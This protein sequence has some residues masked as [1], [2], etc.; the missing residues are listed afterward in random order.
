MTKVSIQPAAASG[1]W[2]IERRWLLIR[3]GDEPQPVA[4]L[5]LKAFKALALLGPAGAG[6]TTE[7]KRLAQVERADDRVVW[8]CRLADHS[9]SADELR[10][11]LDLLTDGANATTSIYLDALDEAMVPLRRAWREILSWIDERAIPVGAAVRITCRSAVWPAGLASRFIDGSAATNFGTALLQPL[12]AADVIAAAQSAGLDGATFMEHVRRFRADALASNALTL[13]LLLRL[14]QRGDLPTSIGDLFDRGM[15][16]LAEDRHER[17]ELGTDLRLSP[18]VILGAAERLACA[19]VL[20]GRETIDLSNDPPSTHLSSHDLEL[21]NESGS[22][23]LD[24]ETLADIGASGLCDSEFPATFRF[25]H[26]QIAEYLAG[27]RLARMLPHQ[28]RGLL[29]SPAGAAEGVAGPL[30]ETAAFAAMLN[31]G[32][33]EWIASTDPEIVGLSD[34]AD[35]QLR[36]TA[37]LGLLERCRRGEL[38]DAQVGRGEIVLDGLQYD[39]AEADLKPVLRERGSG[40]EDVLECAIELIKTWKLSSMSDDLADLM[41]DHT[42]PMEARKSAGHALVKIGTDEVKART[43][44]L[45]ASSPDDEIADLKGL[46]LR[47]NWPRGLTTPDLLAALTE[48]PRSNYHGAYDG[49]LW[50]L[51]RSC[52]NAEGFTVEGLR[53]ARSHLCR[54][55]DTDPLHRIAVRIVHHAVDQLDEP[56]VIVGLVD[57]MAGCAAAHVDSPL[58]ALRRAGFA[59]AHDEPE[60]PPA[61]DANPDARRRLI[62]ALA[63]SSIS[64]GDLWWTALRTPRLCTLDDFPWLIEQACDADRPMKERENYLHIARCLPWTTDLGCVEAW[65]AARGIDPVSRVLDFPLSV[66]LAS[67]EAKKMRGQWALMQDRDSPR[68]PVLLDPPPQERV[69]RCI[70]LAEAKDPKFF[71]NLCRAMT[72]EPASTHYG[73]ERDLTR[74]PGWQ[75]ADP[76]IRGRIV[77][78]A[79]RL[80]ETEAETPVDCR[81]W[82]SNSGNST[83]MS[84]ML[85]VAGSD[86]EW[87]RSR[88]GEWWLRWCHYVV[89]E[90]RLHTAE[91]GD[92]SVFDLLYQSVPAEVRSE[93]NRAST[94]PSAGSA[95]D[96]NRLLDLAMPIEDAVL[97]AEL[98]RR[99]ER[100]EVRED[101]IA[102]IAGFLLTRAPKL[103]V[104]ALLRCLDTPGPDTDDAA[105]VQ[106][107]TAMLTVRPPDHWDAVLAFVARNP[108]HGRR[109]LALFAHGAAYRR[110]NEDSPGPLA[111]FGP[112]RWAELFA[113]LLE[114][115]PPES[116]PVYEGAYFAG[117]DDSAR[118]LRGQLISALGDREDQAAV[119]A[120]RDLERRFGARYPWLRR[121]RAR[122]ERAWRL[123]QWLAL[124]LDVIGEVV[125]STERRLVRSEDDVLEGV[126]RAIEGY[127]R[128]LRQ[129]GAD[130]VEDLWNTASRRPP[131]PKAEEHVSGKICGAIR[132][133]FEDLAIAADREVEIHRRAVPRAAGG[134]P[135]SELDVLVQVPARGTMRGSQIRTPIEVKLSHNPEAK[136]AMKEQLADRYMPELGAMHGVYVVAWMGAPAGN[137]LARA[138]RPR[139]ASIEEARADLERQAAELAESQ[140]ATIVPI[141]IDASIR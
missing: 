130:T 112:A 97:D 141:V 25:A 83:C 77:A 71:I 114:H 126:R 15:R 79:K 85:L 42:A 80:L 24:R 51:E 10:R 102:P 100:G 94:D 127:E 69:L 93:V 140:G 23:P 39:D 18:D 115:F 103:S 56:G 122:A 26:R 84:A 49:F 47:C 36:R 78:A 117:S 21:L 60:L 66:D 86:P 109:V 17:F 82:P 44:P 119:D 118:N 133:Y 3:S 138:H 107:A 38:T 124:P 46:A 8:E 134:E 105:S 81:K 20:T 75:S 34:V 120:L 58:S 11:K 67:E 106:V 110:R 6:K 50:E 129:E 137:G 59:R 108:A 43:K 63:S 40:C 135:G 9:G 125:R 14:S 74:T 98:V 72:L 12:N 116:D 5:N 113:L 7:A 54:M 48:P 13:G 99:L 73:L 121:P 31:A 128:R 90:A 28:A 111:Q 16:E 62:D 35:N 61:L 91:E 19:V 32:I 104:Q 88:S 136:T 4:T 22:R 89:R 139:W 70:E 76:S 131:S 96:V 68:E 95:H 57:I 1:L 53:W 132:S 101:C 45:I 37:T 29:A 92:R 27:R 33:A 52:F 41:L 2:P 30:R 87:L 65:L 123:S 64:D 55:G